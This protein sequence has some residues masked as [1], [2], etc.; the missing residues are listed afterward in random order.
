MNR[1]PTAA[2]TH[3]TDAR[4]HGR[5]TRG[6]GWGMAHAPGRGHVTDAARRGVYGPQHVGPQS[7]RHPAEQRSYHSNP[8]P[9]PGAG[10][11]AGRGARQHPPLTGDPSL[12]RLAWNGLP[13]ISPGR[14]PVRSSR[15]PED[16]HSWPEQTPG[17][18]GA[19]R[20]RG[21]VPG[22]PS[23]PLR[24]AAQACSSRLA[25]APAPH[26]AE[27]GGSALRGPCV[28][29]GRIPCIRGPAAAPQPR[30]LWP[31]RGQ[32]GTQGLTR[33]QPAGS[34]YLFMNPEP[35]PRGSHRLTPSCPPTMSPR[36]PRGGAGGRPGTCVS[37]LE[38]GAGRLA[39]GRLAHGRPRPPAPEA[40]GS[41][42]AS[43]RAA[44]PRGWA[45]RGD[46]GE[47]PPVL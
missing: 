3:H 14:V 42:D 15:A 38:A 25:P 18:L 46:R 29:A 20:L 17:G 12:S 11:L 39:H 10:R 31:L 32:E 6:C 21:N 22:V 24:G 19:A 2:G 47:Q 4:T 35:R 43:G 13:V 27:S 23:A 33:H 5:A 45:F 8:W 16:E 40:H 9:S 34:C 41:V 30:A 37:G 7:Q 44:P 26:G 1:P 28:P 36:L